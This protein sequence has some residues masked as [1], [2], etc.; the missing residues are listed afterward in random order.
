[1]SRTTDSTKTPSEQS[2]PSA[3]Y[4]QELHH[5][6]EYLKNLG[7]DDRTNRLT[8]F[9]ALVEVASERN[10][11]INAALKVADVVESAGR[12]GSAVRN[13]IFDEHR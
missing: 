13:L 3:P 1:M 5:L 7:E 2:N 11:M 4:N 6:I 9:R 12:I 8:A 10:G